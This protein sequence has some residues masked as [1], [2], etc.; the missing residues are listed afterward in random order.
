MIMNIFSLVIWFV[1]NFVALNHFSFVTFIMR[2]IHCKYVHLRDFIMMM[3][4][5]NQQLIQIINVLSILMLFSKVFS[6]LQ[7]GL[8][9]VDEILFLLC[10]SR[11]SLF[12]LFLNSVLFFLVGPP[13]FLFAVSLALSFF[14]SFNFNPCSFRFRLGL[15]LLSFLSLSM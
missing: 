3:M 6:R 1:F 11:L 8:V 13:I 15:Q 2:Q 9:P 10:L 4:L 12:L 14:F 7:V 5:G